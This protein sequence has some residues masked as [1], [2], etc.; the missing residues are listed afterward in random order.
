LAVGGEVEDA[1]FVGAEE[2]A[3]CEEVEDS[4]IDLLAVANRQHNGRGLNGIE[5][6]GADSVGATTLGD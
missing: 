1:V 4:G 2:G 6:K 5:I 3:A